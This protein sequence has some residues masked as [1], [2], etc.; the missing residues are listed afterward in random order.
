MKIFALFASIISAISLS[1]AVAL[2][3]LRETQT[4]D[5]ED[6]ATLPAQAGGAATIS[7]LPEQHRALEGV[8]A[9]ILARK[10]EI[11]RQKLLLDER[12]AR[13]REEEIV[14]R[15]MRDELTSTKQAL[16]ER[17]KALDAE[18]RANTRKLA[19]FYA[20]MEPGNAATLLMELDRAQAARIL[21][22][23]QDRQ[24]GGIINAA[25]GLGD[26]GIEHAAKW[27]EEIR[28]IRNQ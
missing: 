1:L 16:E 13:V 26:H 21:S 5:P 7:L 17:F 28:R 14:L 9:E 8:I 4:G 24:A 25:V 22:N 15:R 2:W 6:L 10:E 12:E 20:R 19:D 3:S 27:S 23:L 11:D 18:D